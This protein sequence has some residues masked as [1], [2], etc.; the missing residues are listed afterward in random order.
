MPKKPKQ[1][2]RTRATPGQ[3]P[4]MLKIEGDWQDAVKKSLKKKKPAGVWPK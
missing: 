4:N 3:K 2:N 1:P